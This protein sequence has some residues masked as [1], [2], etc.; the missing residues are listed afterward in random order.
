MMLFRIRKNK[1]T[2]GRNKTTD[3][4]CVAFPANS[5]AKRIAE[6]LNPINEYKTLLISGTAHLRAFRNKD[7][8]CFWKVGLE[9]KLE[10]YK[11]GLLTT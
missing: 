7:N 4:N 11:K 5:T 2:V 6:N 3:N 1:C 10:G 8:F 9:I